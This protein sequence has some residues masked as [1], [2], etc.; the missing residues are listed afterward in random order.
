EPAAREPDPAAHA[1]LS[2]VVLGR[3]SRTGDGV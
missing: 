1:R 3:G 2:H